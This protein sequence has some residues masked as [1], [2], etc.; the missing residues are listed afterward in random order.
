MLIMYSVV[1]S[2]LIIINKFN[3]N[4]RHF[5]QIRKHDNISIETQTSDLLAAVSGSGHVP[6]LEGILGVCFEVQDLP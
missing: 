2:P 4:T 6:L 1:Q 3:R 5:I